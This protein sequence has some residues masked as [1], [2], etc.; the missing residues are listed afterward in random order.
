MGGGQQVVRGRFGDGAELLFGFGLAFHAEQ[1]VGQFASQFDVGRVELEGGLKLGDE[2]IAVG[3]KLAGEL[4]GAG[5]AAAGGGQQRRGGLFGTAH[6]FPDAAEI[7]QHRAAVGEQAPGL[8]V[9]LG[10]ER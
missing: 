10:G 1:Q 6:G 5:L 7:D 2:R 3:E 9:M 4:G 8:F